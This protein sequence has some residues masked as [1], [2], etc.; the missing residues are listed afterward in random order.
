M[1]AAT[2][3][4]RAGQPESG[5]RLRGRPSRRAPTRSSRPGAA[6][7]TTRSTTCSGFPFIF[8]G[9]LDVRATTIDESMKIAAAHALAELARRDVPQHGV[10]GLR[11]A[12]STS[13][14]LHHPQAVRPARA[15]LGRAGGGQAR[16]SSPAWLPGRSTLD[17]YRRAPARPARAVERGDAQVR[18]PGGHRPA[19]H[20]VPRGVPTPGSCSACQILLD[21]HVAKP[22]LARLGRG[23]PR[24]P[25]RARDRLDLDRLRDRRSEPAI[26]RCDRLRHADL[27]RAAAAQGHGPSA[28]RA[29]DASTATTLA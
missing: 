7:T 12:T 3:R 13:A 21:E 2:D 10:A 9:A 15:P 27:L 23:D 18:A 20:R 16:R 24:R 29:A 1:A 25:R 26:R 4:L 5:D 6:T 28:R 8:R 19:T 22:V 17:A 14:R 11:R